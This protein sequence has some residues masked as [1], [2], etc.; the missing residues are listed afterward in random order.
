MSSGYSRTNNPTPGSSTDGHRQS[1]R[2][3]LFTRSREGEKEE[4]WVISEAPVIDYQFGALR[5]DFDFGAVLLWDTAKLK[6]LV[7]EMDTDYD[8]AGLYDLRLRASQLSIFNSQFS[9]LHIHE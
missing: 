2:A 8:F 6:A 5:D 4:P 1:D 9:I 7:A 3:E